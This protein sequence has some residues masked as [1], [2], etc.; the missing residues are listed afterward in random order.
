MDYRWSILV[1]ASYKH[2]Q[3]RRA[4]QTAL[5]KA[6]PILKEG[7]SA[8][9]IDTNV[10]KVGDG[11]TAWRNLSEFISTRTLKTNAIIA[12]IPA[13]TN[14]N[15]GSVLLTFEGLKSENDYFVIT[16]P[17]TQLPANLKIDYSYVSSDNTV[18]VEL[19]AVGGDV[20][21]T[22]SVKLYVAA[23]TVNEV[24]VTTTEAPDP[25]PEINEAYSFGGNQFGQLSQINFIGNNL[26]TPKLIDDSENWSSLSAGNYHSAGTSDSKKLYTSGYNYYGQL[27]QGDSGP[28]KNK[29][30]FTEVSTAYEEDSARTKFAFSNLAYSG[31]SAGAN[32]TATITDNNGR[33]FTVGNNAYG[34]LGLGNTAQRDNL[35]LVSKEAGRRNIDFDY[36]TGIPV[37]ITNNKYNFTVFNSSYAGTQNFILNRLGEHKILNVPNSGHAMAIIGANHEDNSN[38]NSN[39]ISYSGQYFVN[40]G[41]IDSVAYPFYSGDISIDVSGNYGQ[42]KLRSLD[43]GDAGGTVFNYDDPD[44]G[45]SDVSAGQQH[46]LGI[47]RGKLYAWGNNTFGQ[48]GD[49]SYT[50]YTKPN[51]ASE[52]IDLS[53]DVSW[54]KVSAGDYH[55]LALD[56]N[57]RVWS[58]GQNDF[59]QLGHKD[60][61]DRLKFTQITGTEESLSSEF[62][63]I[64]LDPDSFTRMDGNNLVINLPTRTSTDSYNSRNRYLV[65][66]GSFILYNIATG[67]AITLL[68][69]NIDGISVT[70]TILQE[71]TTITGTEND[72]TYNFYAGDVTITVDQD[73]GSMSLYS[74]KLSYAGGQDLLHYDSLSKKVTDISAGNGYS[75][76]LNE[77]KEVF[78]F[79]SNEHGKLGLGDEINRNF[80]VKLEGVVWS[81]I[82]AGSNHS[83]FVDEYRN[84]W[85]A[86]S[87][88]R[89]GLG[90]GDD[91][92]RTHV[93]KINNDI[94]W[95]KPSAGGTHSI[96]GVFSYYPNAPT[97][98]TAKNASSSN[99]AGHYEIDVEWIA[100]SSLIDGVKYYILEEAPNGTTDFTPLS[101]A[102]SLDPPKRRIIPY[103]AGTGSKI[104]R[105]KAV[106]AFGESAYSPVSSP[107]TPI[108]LIDPE[109][110]NV[111]FLTHFN[112]DVE[113]SEERDAFFKD[114]SKNDMNYQTDLA[115][116][117]VST[118]GGK[119][120][121]ALNPF[122]TDNV[123]YDVPDTLACTGNFTVEFWYKPIDRS[124]G[125]TI[126]EI[127][128][129]ANANKIKI[130]YLDNK[131][132]VDGFTDDLLSQTLPQD[133]L[134]HHI[135]WVRKVGVNYLW[136]DESRSTTLSES[137]P[138]S[139]QATSSSKINLQHGLIDEIRLTNNVARYDET[140][141]S[142]VIRSP[143]RPFGESD[144]TPCP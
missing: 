141:G 14:G 97:V 64:S 50:N 17:D 74:R 24:I 91:L 9:A 56:S 133:D 115:V 18:K 21:L 73:F 121:S 35:I 53:S 38:I 78:V 98:I 138:V 69:N 100:D 46:M 23:Y 111:E 59:G 51:L 139:Y 108:A 6:N 71:T 110:C 32:N 136:V 19:S 130:R 90:L 92:D 48:L 57:G 114:Y 45:W 95:A 79:G 75:L 44:G 101:H 31:V 4:T 40:S 127:S 81:E 77:D 120:G 63:V 67:D 104:Y 129:L 72:G 88:E 123:R 134:W 42:V 87:N 2:I 109:Y 34:C 124:T 118:D 1:S 112:G 5:D 102:E 11:K 15:T 58:C 43:Y 94:N 131:I 3:V 68:N 13:I 83:L 103:S 117:P 22:T 8:F 85:S 143:Q 137:S 96:V 10:L 132:E 80:P 55:S 122:A 66:D 135:A 107:I 26:N 93:T 82:S 105:V 52:S 54:S 125:Q 84:L 89:G 116:R 28:N 25:I 70:G 61:T 33:L 128:D 37:T 41:V 140:Y 49:N 29:N 106:N 99:R 142:D 30:V 12:T 47:K 20:A 126:F 60:N 16:N 27:A 76:L 144:G 62:N 7:E 39:K 65:T 119:F 86:G 113:Q 36:I